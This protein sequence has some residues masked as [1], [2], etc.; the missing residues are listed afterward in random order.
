MG[1]FSRIKDAI[2]PMRY[3]SG[4]EKAMYW[5][6]KVGTIVLAV[7]VVIIIAALIYCAATGTKIQMPF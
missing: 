3:G 2:S 5:F 7:V 4:S 6:I 1:F